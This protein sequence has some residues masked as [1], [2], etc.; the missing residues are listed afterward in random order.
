MQRL[1]ALLVLLTITCLPRPQFMPDETKFTVRTYAVETAPL[2]DGAFHAVNAL[3]E[4]RNPTTQNL[5]LYAGCEFSEDNKVFA[6]TVTKTFVQAGE[7][8]V[9]RLNTPLVGP[10]IGRSRLTINCRYETKRIK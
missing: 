3:V 1:A 6:T 9:F 5:L 8:K 10:I 7:V 4:A 2:H